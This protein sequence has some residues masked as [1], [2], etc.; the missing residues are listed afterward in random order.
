MDMA[1][2][3]R[4]Q[5]R[6]G[7]MF[8]PEIGKHAEVASRAELL[9]WCAE[10]DATGNWIVPIHIDQAPALAAEATQPRQGWLG[11][12]ITRARRSAESENGIAHTV[13]GRAPTTAAKTEQRLGRPLT[14]AE[15]ATADRISG[16][17]TEQRLGRPLTAA[18]Q[19][20]ANRISDGRSRAEMRT[21]RHSR[22]AGAL[23][24]LA[25][26]RPNRNRTTGEILNHFRQQGAVDP[27]VVRTFREDY[28]DSLV[29]LVADLHD[30]ADAAGQPFDADRAMVQLSGPLYREMQARLFGSTRTGIERQFEVPRVIIEEFDGLFTQIED[31]PQPPTQEMPITPPPAAPR[32]APGL[33]PG[34]GHATT[35]APVYGLGAGPA[36]TR[37]GPRDESDPDEPAA[38]PAA[39][40]QEQAAGPAFDERLRQEI[41]DVRSQL[42]EQG[43]AP[44]KLDKKT[45]TRLM[46]KYKDTSHEAAQFL[47]THFHDLINT[48]QGDYKDNFQHHRR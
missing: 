25:I 36:Y 23:G 33:S 35:E 3:L 47:T 39:S 19:A 48:K 28:Q 16:A 29:T 20:E 10:Q 13:T 4:R 26:N 37:P 18:E 15:Q 40:N 5:Q 8:R 21:D 34:S 1:D 30:A 14:A 7:G 12:R 9:A 6:M 44:E 11:R 27:D 22:V 42:E 46:L 24:G 41:M 43:I 45:F 38:E 32:P 2:L 17:N 31:E